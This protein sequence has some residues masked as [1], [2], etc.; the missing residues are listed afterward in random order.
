MPG[1]FEVSFYVVVHG[2]HV[3]QAVW[4]PIV[5]EVLGTQRELVSLATPRERG[6]GDHAYSELFRRNAIIT[7]HVT[8]N[9]KQCGPT[10]LRV[11]RQ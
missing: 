5:G 2:F 11:R 6:S 9:R 7:K 10:V 1:D 8:G 4:T 3:Y